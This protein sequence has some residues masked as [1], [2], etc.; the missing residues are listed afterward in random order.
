MDPD[1]G[2][3]RVTRLPIHLHAFK[4][5]GLRNVALTAPYM[6]NGVYR[7]LEEV[8]E[9]YNLGGGLGIGAA[10]PNQTLPFDSL[11]LTKAEQRALVAFMRTLTDTTSVPGMGRLGAQVEAIG[12]ATR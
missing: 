10:L 11:A 5:P 12:A 1:S 7:T 6:H 9:F 4:T 3:A 8:V 2:R